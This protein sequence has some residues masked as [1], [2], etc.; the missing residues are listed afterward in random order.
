MLVVGVIKV[1]SNA[2]NPREILIHMHNSCEYGYFVLDRLSHCMLPTSFCLLVISSNSSFSL[3]FCYPLFWFSSAMYFSVPSM[4]TW[5]S[6]T[7]CH[8]GP[9][10]VT[11]GGFLSI[12]VPYLHFYPKFRLICLL[13]SSAVSITPCWE[14]AAF[15]AASTS[16]DCK[17]CT[18]R[19]VLFLYACSTI[20][21]YTGWGGCS[22]RFLALEFYSWP[23]VNT[24]NIV[25]LSYSCLK[26]DP[27]V[28]YMYMT[29]LAMVRC[30]F[31]L[32]NRTHFLILY[33]LIV[34]LFNACSA[35][36][37]SLPYMTLKFVLIKFWCSTWFGHCM[38]TTNNN[39]LRNRKK[40]SN[41]LLQRSNHLSYYAV[42]KCVY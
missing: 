3:G 35:W 28:C 36:E 2:G 32:K 33:T 18:L 8:K 41:A 5:T 42:Q 11:C 10:Y 6:V 27:D 7:I 40:R 16:V 9:L 13:K 4:D 12:N 25:I 39:W 20:S 26:Q 24:F 31:K 38:E 30:T 14:I 23:F 21:T 1:W 34:E 15:L 17:D 22:W 37:K 19:W 29:I